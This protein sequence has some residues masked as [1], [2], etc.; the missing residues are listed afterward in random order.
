MKEFGRPEHSDAPAL[1]GLVL[2]GGDSQRMGRDKAQ[3]RYHRDEPQVRHAFDLLAAVAAGAYVSVRKAQ[4][5]AGLYATF[6]LIIDDGTMRGPAAGLLAA[7]S[8]APQVAWLV[9]ATDL[10]FV[11][12]A[13]VADL[14]AGR[15]VSTLATA[16]RHRDGTPE[17]LCTIWEPAARPILLGRVG[18][19]DSS[20]RRL[21]VDGPV[22]ML[23]AS[24]PDLLRSVDS[25]RQYETARAEIVAR[26]LGSATVRSSRE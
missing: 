9:L 19:G 16:F 14:L 11:S 26:T 13:L 5:D 23:D 21:L 1:Y 15:D 8:H 24:D 12:A 2:A 25:E 10:P 7:W 4:A 22:K 3:L 6:P 20:L 18:S 17:P